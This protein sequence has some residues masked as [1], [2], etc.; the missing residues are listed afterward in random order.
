MIKDL[1]NRKL[2][3]TEADASLSKIAKIM[4]QEDVGCVLVLDES[5]RPR[6]IMTDRDIVTRCIAKRIDVDDCTVENV[7]SESVLTVKETDDIFDCIEVMRGARVR[8]IP[9][10]DEHGKAVGLISLGDLLTVLSKELIGLTEANSS[11]F[12]ELRRAS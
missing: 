7:M 3:V 2:V 6:G 8:R 10:V 12:R 11:Q 9:V 4:E 5:E 1:I